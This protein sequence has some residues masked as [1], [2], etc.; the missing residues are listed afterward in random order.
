MSWMRGKE[1]GS[2]GNYAFCPC[3]KFNK[4]PFC[5]DTYEEIGFEG[6][7]AA[8]TGPISDRWVTFDGPKIVIRDD[9]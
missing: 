3:S 6:T 2:G 7:E 1:F 4:K 9:Y 8:D 5:D